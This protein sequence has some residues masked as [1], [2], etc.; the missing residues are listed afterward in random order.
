MRSVYRTNTGDEVFEVP[1]RT[2]KEIKKPPVYRAKSLKR[3]AWENGIAF[4]SHEQVLPIFDIVCT[5]ITII[6]IEFKD[7][8]VVNI[9]LYIIGTV[10]NRYL[11]YTQYDN[12]QYIVQYGFLYKRSLYIVFTEHRLYRLLRNRYLGHI[13]VVPGTYCCY[14]GG[15][16][17]DIKI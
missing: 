10:F 11:R 4:G 9:I 7:F 17:G 2:R 6:I 14:R 12:I 16:R 15:R 13:E 1:R 3:L 5:R 8:I